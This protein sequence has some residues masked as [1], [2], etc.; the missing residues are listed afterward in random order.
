MK[1][2]AEHTEESKLKMS[3]TAKE[4][5][6]GKSNKGRKMTKEHKEACR[7]RLLKNPLKYWLGKKREGMTKEKNWRWQGG[8]TPGNQKIRDSEEYKKWRLRIFFRDDFACKKC[9][10]KKNSIQ[11]HHIESFAKNEKLRFEEFNGITLCK[12]CHKKFHKKY[13]LNNNSDQLIKF[14]NTIK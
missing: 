11:A 6:I 12:E 14:L 9:N 10:V 1:K 8:I 5:G 3:K 13:G 7:R 4:R 2:G